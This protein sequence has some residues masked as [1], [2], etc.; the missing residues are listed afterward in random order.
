MLHLRKKNK[1]DE[2]NSEVLKLAAQKMWG[3]EEQ[4]FN[5]TMPEE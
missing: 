3:L 5:N 2:S 4:I 1:S